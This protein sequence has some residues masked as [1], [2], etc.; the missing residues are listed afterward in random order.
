M[1]TINEIL[2][3]REVRGLQIMVIG[4]L[5]FLAIG[6]V[7]NFFVAFSK[8]EI[9]VTSIMYGSIFVFFLIS[10]WF[11]NRKQYLQFIGISSACIDAAILAVMPY[12][13]YLSVGGDVI[14]RA[15]L[16]KT[17]IP[18][19]AIMFILINSLA[20]R[21]LYPLIVSIGFTC[22]QLGWVFYAMED[23]RTLFTENY[24]EVFLGAS[25]HSG[26]SFFGP[27]LFLLYGGVLALITHLF[28]KS[29]FEAVHFEKANTQMQR[30]FSPKVAERITQAEESFLQPGGQKQN[31]AVLF[32][33]IRGFTTLSEEMTPEE[34][35]E[36]LSEYHSKMVD[37]IFQYGGTLDKFIGDGIMA[38]FG[39]PDPQED[40]IERAVQAGIAMTKSLQELNEN[41]NQRNIREIK[42]GIGI[43]FGPVIA[44]N[45]GTQQRL[46]YT[47][48]G[49]TVNIASRI[50][51]ACKELK[52]DFLISKEVQVHLSS[53][54]LTRALGEIS[55]KGK[56]MPIHVYAVDG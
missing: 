4:K 40:D 43:H 7:V 18:F 45:I 32:S 38:T 15:Y 10:L 42:Q 17:Q 11:I 24:L 56:S 33:D 22:S 9:I 50:E 39:T 28:R 44:G 25:V 8:F 46:E 14:P 49:D 31:V 20:V 6:G 54:I 12:I 13:F 27:I 35:V 53:E 5:L 30:Y 51:S 16:L 19:L 1:N 34:V 41:R 36:L 37:A 3:N 2:L 23:E 26:F 47:V 48:I 52:E 29:I 55:V 21:P